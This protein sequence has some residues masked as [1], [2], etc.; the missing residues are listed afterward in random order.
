MSELRIFNYHF[1]EQLGC[2]PT[3]TDGNVGAPMPI[4]RE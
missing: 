2:P 3:I 4:R 1:P